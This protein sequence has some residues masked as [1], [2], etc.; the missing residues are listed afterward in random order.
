MECVSC[1]MLT[2]ARCDTSKRVPFKCLFCQHEDDGD[3][4]TFESQEGSNDDLRPMRGDSGRSG[5][6]A[7]FES[8]EV[9]IE[10]SAES[11]W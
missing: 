11:R 2:H 4:D 7:T 1:D 10:N 8:R 6:D 5:D 9:F 3:L